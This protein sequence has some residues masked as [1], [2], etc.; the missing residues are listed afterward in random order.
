M[1]PLG[2]MSSG[3]GKHT[4]SGT[5]CLENLIGLAK[6]MSERD[7]PKSLVDGNIHK[8]RGRRRP[9]IRWEGFVLLDTGLILKVMEGRSKTRS[10]SVKAP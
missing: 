5:G 9:R 6:R 7:M 3:E 4:L 10:C 1:A 8:A 2:W